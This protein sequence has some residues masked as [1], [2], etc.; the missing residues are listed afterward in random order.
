M[1]G[2]SD[3]FCAMAGRSIVAAITPIT[4]PVKIKPIRF[5]ILIWPAYQFGVM[6]VAITSPSPAPTKLNAIRSGRG[7]VTG[8]I[9]L[10]RG[11]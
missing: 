1:R 11:T 10:N 9:T 6:R 4:T 7:E 2:F 3:A 5:A 8:W